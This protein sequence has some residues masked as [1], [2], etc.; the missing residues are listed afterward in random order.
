MNWYVST[1]GSV[2]V[3]TSHPAAYNIGVLQLCPD[4]KQALCTNQCNIQLAG[5]QFTH[6]LCD[7]QYNTQCTSKIDGSIMRALLQGT[8]PRDEKSYLGTTSCGS[9]WTESMVPAITTWNDSKPIVHLCCPL[10][11]Q[12][13]YC[14][15]SV[16]TN[17]SA[18]QSTHTAVSNYNSL[19]HTSWLPSWCYSWHCHWS[20]IQHKG[21]LCSK[22]RS[23]R[24]WS[25]YMWPFQIIQHLINKQHTEIYSSSVFCLSA[26]QHTMCALVHWSLH[27]F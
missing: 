22:A 19:A 9:P 24:T 13:Y 18:D 8:V 16:V 5:P 2:N 12:Q 3:N 4:M 10:V 21:I 7:C 23:K 27:D 1:A 17:T 15:C 26:V 25:V 11:V 14:K 6:N 20:P